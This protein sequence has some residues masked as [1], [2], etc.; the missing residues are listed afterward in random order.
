MIPSNEISQDVELK[1]VNGNLYGRYPKISIERTVNMIM[2][3]E[4]LVDYAGYLNVFAQNS[5]TKLPNPLSTVGVGRGAYHST[6]LNRLV[7]VV[8]NQAWLIDPDLNRFLMGTL[9][10]VTGDVF[11][12]EDVQ[13]HIAI[14][15]KTQIWIYTDATGTFKPATKDGSAALDF[16]PGYVAYH[17]GRFL[18]VDI[19]PAN[20]SGNS[21]WR[22]S[23]PAAGNATFPS[24]SQFIGGFTTKSDLPI[25][26]VPLPGKSNHIMIIGSNSAEFWTDTGAAL[27]PYQKQTG[28]NIDYGTQNADTVAIDTDIVCWLAGNEKSGPFIAYSKGGLPEKISTDGIDFQLGN[29]SNPTNSHGFFFRQDGHLI[30]QLTFPSDNLSLIY[31]FNTQK[32]FTV[33]D[34]NSNYH[35]AKRAAY[36]NGTYYFVSLNDGNLYQF[37]TNITNYNYGY[38]N[39]QQLVQ[40]EIPR[41][42]LMQTVRQE[43]GSLFIANSLAIPFEMGVQPDPGMSVVRID[44]T[45]PGSGYTNAQVMLYGGGGQGATAAV[46]IGFFDLLTGPPFLLLNG[47]NFLLLDSGSV[48]AIELENPGVNYSTP[49]TVVITGDGTGARALAVLSQSTVARADISISQN[50]GQSFGNYVGLNFNTLGNYKNRFTYFDGLGCANEFTLQLRLWAQGRFTL[51]NGVLT[52]Y[53]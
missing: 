13:G 34:E 18:S 7:L 52:T 12:A 16:T 43:D 19:N 32:F 1:V 28:V 26:I 10:T 44:V 25:C 42:R 31:D 47:S 37:D 4:W 35:I 53:Q 11:I 45:N 39:K 49:P 21:N 46:D 3:Q 15:D 22:L 5:T 50:G 41:A 9:N 38:N 20:Y 23:N 17:N 33:T 36:F 29:L 2:S 24:G 14:C 30:Y 27:F 40:Y 8:Y 48:L 6:K 51:G